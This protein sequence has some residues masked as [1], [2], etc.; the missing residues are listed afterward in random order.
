MWRSSRLGHDR[1]R[2]DDRLAVE[3]RAKIVQRRDRDAGPPFIGELL[4]C[5]RI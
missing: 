3:H 5:E 1:R 2:D 4:T